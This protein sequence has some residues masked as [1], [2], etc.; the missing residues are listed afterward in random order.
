LETKFRT[1]K[2]DIGRSE[3]WGDPDYSD[4]DWQLCSTTTGWQNQKVKD[5]DGLPLMSK[6]GHS[7]QGLGWYR[8]TTE[9]RDLEKGKQAHLFCPALLD[10]AWVWVNGKYAGR[11]DYVSCFS[12]PHEVDI[13]ITSNL[14]PGKN[15]IALRVLCNDE[16]FGANGF[17]ERP[18]LYTKK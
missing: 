8:F 7:Y 3:R 14:R 11:S 13:D 6:E 15:V 5:Q 1:D 10:Q 4:A 17:Y 18:F 2:Y 9:L 12:R 16:Y